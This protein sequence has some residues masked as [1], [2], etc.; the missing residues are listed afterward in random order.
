M[1]VFGKHYSGGVCEV[2][3][4]VLHKIIPYLLVMARTPQGVTVVDAD[5]VKHT[6]NAILIKPM[7]DHK[8]LLD[9][10]EAL[11]LFLAPYSD[12]ADKLGDVVG[13][14]E[15]ALMPLDALPFTHKSSNKQIFG[16]LDDVM[17]KINTKIDPRLAIALHDLEESASSI[18]LVEIA[19][20]CDISPSR[21]RVIAKQELGVSL[22]ALLVWRKL[23]NAMKILS[24]GSSLSEAASEGGFSDQAHFT[25]T[26]RRVFGITPADSM[27]ALNY[28]N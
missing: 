20:R 12:F 15:I 9:T 28:E 1:F 26:M 17:H 14:A 13:D 18:S 6:G 21:L 24:S 7:V 25:R 4:S 11:H 22:S 10:G 27:K 16:V 3:Q 5:G 19:N 8:F 23:V 2:Y